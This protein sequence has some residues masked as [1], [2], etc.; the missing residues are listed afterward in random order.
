MRWTPS[1]FTVGI[2]T[3]FRGSPKQ[4]ALIPQ[5]STQ[6]IK[7]AM[8]AAMGKNLPVHYHVTQLRVTHADDIH[9][10]WYLR[11]D[12]LAAIASFAGEAF[13]S[14]QM[15]DISEM[16]VGLVPKTMMSKGAQFSR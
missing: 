10:L 6:E 16:F 9:D 11:A 2:N 12:V 1:I 15:E 4:K 14:K 8:L 5:K 13:A 3:L 7:N